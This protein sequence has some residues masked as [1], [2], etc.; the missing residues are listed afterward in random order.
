MR[1][2]DSLLRTV[3]AIAFVSMSGSTL[4]AQRTSFGVLVGGVA[5][6]VTDVDVGSADLF[7]GLSTVENR[8][9]F[10]AGVYVNRTFGT[11]WSLQPE[12]HYIQKGTVFDVSATPVSGSLS[13]DLAY[14]EVPVLLRADLGTAAWRPF[15]TAG[16][17]IA[18]RIG[19]KGTLESGSSTLSVDCDEFE[20]NG[21]KRDPFETTDFGV[22]VGA[23]ITGKMGGRSALVQLRYGR[24]LTSIITDASSSTAAKSP[25]NSV[26]SLV[27]GFGN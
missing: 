21:T 23:G 8:Y 7:N 26:I 10:Q 2:R 20:D 3:V 14:V 12:L 13:I 24:G 9:G 17:T 15:I 22:N 11:M 4:S 5:A 19:C 1:V 18:M 16:P 27:F 6:K 25:K